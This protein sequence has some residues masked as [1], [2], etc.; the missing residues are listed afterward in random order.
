VKT[1]LICSIYLT[2]FWLV[3]HGQRNHRLAIA[4]AAYAICEVVFAIYM[5]Y[6][7]RRVQ[8]PSP[9]SS[10]S[11]DRRQELLRKIMTADL[12]ADPRDDMSGQKL[13]ERMWEMLGGDRKQPGSEAVTFGT[14]GVR[15]RSRKKDDGQQRDLLSEKQLKRDIEVQVDQGMEQ[16]VGHMEQLHHSHPRAIEFRE[17]LRTWS[18]PS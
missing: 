6:T 17:R 11:P 13:Q 4:A 12:A 15:T 10:L 7:I 16:P 8:R 9:P 2:W 3:Y 1:R 5:E 18:A 14:E